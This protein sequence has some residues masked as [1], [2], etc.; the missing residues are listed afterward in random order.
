MVT[1]LVQIRSLGEKKRAENERFRGHLKPA[2]TRSAFC[3][4]SPKALKTGSI[5]Q[6]APTAAE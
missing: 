2:I 6:C 3:G 4:G 5:A 1:D